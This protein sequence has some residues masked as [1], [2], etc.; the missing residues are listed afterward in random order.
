M[1]TSFI[2]FL[3][4]GLLSTLVLS[5]CT[6][7]QPSTTLTAEDY[8]GNYRVSEECGSQTDTYTLVIARGNAPSQV[9]IINLYNTGAEGSATV[10]ARG[11]LSL[12][13][14]E[15]VTTS[16]PNCQFVTERGRG[17]L[18]GDELTLSFTIV[19]GRYS[20]ISCEDPQLSCVIT[21]YR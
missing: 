1:N 14:I 20:F 10:N 2:K 19:K 18:D 9:R 21:G 6:T 16:S 3:I 5:S 4:G 11:D 8:I 13:T 12:S 17:Q 7:E 15:V